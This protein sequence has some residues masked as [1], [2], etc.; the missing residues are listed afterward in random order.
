[1][2]N[3]FS[4]CMNEPYGVS[5]DIADNRGIELTQDREPLLDNIEESPRQF[6]DTDL[7]TYN[8]IVDICRG[9]A[10][11]GNTYTSYKDT[12]N[13]INETVIELL[14]NNGYEIERMDLT[15]L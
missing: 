1:M 10:R 9:V 14:N 5:I 11:H 15:N 4:K 13:N 12:N 7:L 3:P 8:S 6:S 2:G